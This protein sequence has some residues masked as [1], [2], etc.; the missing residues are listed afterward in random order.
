MQ[1]EAPPADPL[2]WLRLLGRAYARF[3][4]ENPNH[5]RFMFMSPLKPDHKPEPGD[6][7][8]TSFE[9]LRAAVVRALESGALRPGDPDTVSQVLWASLHGALALLITL[10]PDCWPRPPVADLV[11]ETIEAGL[12]AFRA[13]TA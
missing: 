1:E 7:G 6:P 9:V 3:A 11:D 2:E 13:T 10:R 8:H 5:Y 12:R 4:L